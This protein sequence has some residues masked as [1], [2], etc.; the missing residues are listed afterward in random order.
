MTE[1]VSLAEVCHV[2]KTERCGHRVNMQM[3]IKKLQKAW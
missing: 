3:Q 1:P 2:D